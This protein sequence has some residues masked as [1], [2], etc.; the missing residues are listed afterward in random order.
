MSASATPPTRRILLVEDNTDTRT[1][2]RMLL[3]LDGHTV[4][5]AKDGLEALKALLLNRYDVA[6]V[7]VNLPAMDGYEFVRTVRDSP[8]GKAMSLV[9]VT[10]GSG[11]G[12]E[13][14]EAFEAGFDAFLLKP[15]SSQVVNAILMELPRPDQQSISVDSAMPRFQQ[16]DQARRKKND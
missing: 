9:A 1:W 4:D 3:E 12:H 6:F 7:D 11:R 5:E 15:V 2:M 16:P 8:F 14:D 13:R 10:G